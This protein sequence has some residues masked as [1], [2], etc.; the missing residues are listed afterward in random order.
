M[1]KFWNEFWNQCKWPFLLFAI[2]GITQFAIH[3]RFIA[4]VALIAS[5][6]GIIFWQRKKLQK[7]VNQFKEKYADQLSKN[8]LLTEIL[9]EEFGKMNSEIET[10]CYGMPSLVSPRGYAVTT[11]F[12]EDLH[13]IGF[14][15]LCNTTQSAQLEPMIASFVEEWNNR[16]S[17]QEITLEYEA[18][19]EWYKKE[20]KKYLLNT[21]SIDIHLLIP[22]KADKAA[23]KDSLHELRQFVEIHSDK[24]LHR[25]FTLSNSTRLVYRGQYLEEATKKGGT[26]GQ[27]K[28]KGVYDS[29]YTM[30]EHVKNM[31][32]CHLKEFRD[33]TDH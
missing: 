7:G 15:F 4:F 1:K 6:F 25:E 10:D 12:G 2:W 17:K 27:D 19:E 24:I 28:T 13:N 23:Y 5:Y 18:V 16:Y 26:L 21:V 29:L 22:F 14:G 33:L 32:F 20:Y 8:G 30:M 31:N 11:D 9:A 3:N